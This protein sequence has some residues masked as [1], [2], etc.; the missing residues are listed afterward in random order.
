MEK[1]IGHKIVQEVGRFRDA[2]VRRIDHVNKITEEEVMSAAS[3]VGRIVDRATQLSLRTSQ[4]LSSLATSTQDAD[5]DE[6]LAGSI[7]RQSANVE[8]FVD[9][10]VSHVESQRTVAGEAQT[11]TRDIVLAARS[12]ERLSQQATI[13]ALNAMVE[14]ARMGNQG[15]SFLVISNEMQRLSAEIKKTNTLV[16]S[17]AENLGE[18]LPSMSSLVENAFDSTNRFSVTLSSDISSV[19]K[20]TA[21]LQEGV[22]EVLASNEQAVG[23]ILRESQEALSHLQFQDS[24]AQG[25]KRVDAM[26]RK[27]QLRNASLAGIDSGHLNIATT[28]LEGSQSADVATEDSGSVMLF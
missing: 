4:L 20:K 1:S 17:L 9:D 2:L 21:L 26:A 12:V 18:L 14:A 7:E 13:I 19:R 3:G 6:S 8:A 22:G 25:L 10:I 16:S 15:T 24:V 23:A 27:L 11:C 5:A 28:E